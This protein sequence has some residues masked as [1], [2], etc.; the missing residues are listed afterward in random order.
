ME[1]NDFD[2]NK[3]IQYG[4]HEDYDYYLNC[5]LRQRNKGLFVADQVEDY[6]YIK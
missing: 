5:K 6:S 2:C 4:L 1:C 3:D